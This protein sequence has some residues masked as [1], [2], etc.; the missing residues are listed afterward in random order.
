ME[1]ILTSIKK[2]LGISEE[3]EHFDSDIMM[4]IN[5]VFSILNQ[6]GVGPESGF[7]IRD[8]TAVWSD[9]IQDDQKIDMVKSYIYLK[10]KLIFDP[11]I[12]SAV[13]ESIKQL[14]QELE[15]RLN[16][17][18]DPKSTEQEGKIQNE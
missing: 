15:W 12:S 2:M 13:M 9:F 4:H 10:V 3:Y 5:S 7:S 16:V 11:P 6:L 8:K 17:A 1:S 14:T 18:V